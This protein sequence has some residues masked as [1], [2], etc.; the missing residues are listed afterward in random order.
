MPDRPMTPDE[1]AR[2]EEEV[3]QHDDSGRD[4][5]KPA[6]EPGAKHADRRQPEQPASIVPP[7]PD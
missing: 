4:L 3:V 5:L 1:M 7:P 2:F 6:T